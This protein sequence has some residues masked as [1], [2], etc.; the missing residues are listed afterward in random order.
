[1]H[2]VQFMLHPVVSTL[3]VNILTILE[4]L[5]FPVLYNKV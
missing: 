4:D 2:K 3:L 1:M 5:Y